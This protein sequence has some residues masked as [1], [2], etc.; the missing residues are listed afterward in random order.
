MYKVF[1]SR[2]AEKYY[3]KLSPREKRRFNQIIDRLE[4][5]PFYYLVHIK[6]MA[7]F[8]DRYRYR[9]GDYRVVYSVN[10]REKSVYVIAIRRRGDV[11]KR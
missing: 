10:N 11:Y 6:K 7:G 2:E 5:N 8:R 9:E 3:L 4:E 1:L